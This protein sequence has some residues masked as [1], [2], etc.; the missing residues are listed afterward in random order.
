MRA[1][2]SELEATPGILPESRRRCV[3]CWR[4]FRVRLEEVLAQFKYD[5][6][7]GAFKL[8]VK[9]INIQILYLS[10]KFK[11][12]CIIIFLMLTFYLFYVYFYIALI[13]FCCTLNQKLSSKLL[14]FD[15]IHVILPFSNPILNKI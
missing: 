5:L 1:R 15:M 12:Y 3:R 4:V 6:N 8:F 9:I 11:F 14:S 13:I 2:S 10:T 7:T